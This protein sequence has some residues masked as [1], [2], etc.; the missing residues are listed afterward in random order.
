MNFESKFTTK[1]S[2][3]HLVLISKLTKVFYLRQAER[4]RISTSYT[5]RTNT[6]VTRHVKFDDLLVIKFIGRKATCCDK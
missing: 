4:E 3:N 5:T 1:H 2:L 6:V